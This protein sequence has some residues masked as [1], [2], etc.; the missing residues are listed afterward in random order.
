MEMTPFPEFMC[1][2]NRGAMSSNCAQMG[3]STLQAHPHATSGIGSMAALRMIAFK[4]VTE[5]DAAAND[6]LATF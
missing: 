3:L 4:S 2:S 5:N 1:N 6:L